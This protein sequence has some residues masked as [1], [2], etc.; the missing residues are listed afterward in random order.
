MLWTKLK[1]VTRAG[2]IGFWRN[3]YLSFA[4]IVV[5]TISLLVFGNLIFLNAIS[6]T[7]LTQIKEKV[8]VN[9]YFSLAATESDIMNLKKALEVLPEVSR[10]EYVSRDQVLAAFKARHAD[11]TLTLQGLEEIGDNPF[12]AELNIKAKEPSQYGSVAKFLESKNA[13]GSEG[14]SIVDSVN[15]NK[16]KVIIDRL[17]RITKNAE[18]MGFVASILLALIA[19]IITFN[20]IRLIIYSSKDEIAVMKLVGA[21]NRYI[22]GPFVVSGIMCGIISGVVTLLAL[23]PITYYAGKLILSFS[24][25][26]AAAQPNMLLGYYIAHF[27][28]MFLIIMGSGIVLGAVSSYLAVRRYLNV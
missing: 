18:T 19:I 28:Q 27:G 17:G 3:G 6:K 24:E 7:Y 5:L 13:L 16:N 10:V 25:V 8:D 15:Y 23:Y 26:G 2:F 9:V 22:R 21:S 11:D 12:P 14:Q 4:S 20:T 1:R